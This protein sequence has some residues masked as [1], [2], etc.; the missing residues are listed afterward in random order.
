MKLTQKRRAVICDID[1][2]LAHMGERS[3]YDWHRVSEDTADQVVIDILRHYDDH[4]IILVSGRDEVCRRE[5]VDWL[6]DNRVPFNYL[7]MRKEKDNR[8]DNM[9]KQEIFDNDIKDSFTISFVLDDRNQ[10]VNM[11]RSNGLKCLQVENGAFK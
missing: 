11:W 1:G 5:T 4:E 3:P 6:K 9:V 10:V 7:F 8:K 2:T